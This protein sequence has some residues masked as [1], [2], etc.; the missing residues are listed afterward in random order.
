[1][2]STLKLHNITC[3]FIYIYIYTLCINGYMLSFMDY[4]PQLFKSDN[5]FQVDLY[6]YW[7]FN[8]ILDMFCCEN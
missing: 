8:I 2:F 1:M 7:H 6:I 4:K 5:Y 3:V